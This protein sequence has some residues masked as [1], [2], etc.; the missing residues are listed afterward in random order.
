MV[1]LLQDLE[2]AILNFEIERAEEI[3]NRAVSEKIDLMEA[4][5]VMTRAI[6]QI[7]K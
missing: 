6:K 3:A 5:S 4:V 2:K 7:N 1:T